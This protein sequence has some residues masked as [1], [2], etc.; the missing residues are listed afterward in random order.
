LQRIECCV[1]RRKE[2]G[3]GE[4]DTYGAK[5]GDAFDLARVRIRAREDGLEDDGE[6]ERVERRG[7]GAGDDGAGLWNVVARG[8]EG[9][10]GAFSL[11]CL[12][13]CS[14]MYDIPSLDPVNL[15]IHPPHAQ[16]A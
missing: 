10:G 16:P 8:V 13:A 2:R 9:S 3:R 1:G 14:L 5:E 4:G 6:V 15:E 7:E 11:C 12:D